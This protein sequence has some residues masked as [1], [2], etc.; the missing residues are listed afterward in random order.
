M[1]L[2]SKMINDKCN[3]VGC[4]ENMILSTFRPM[5]HHQLQ[6]IHKKE[7]QII[8]NMVKRYMYHTNLN[9]QRDTNQEVPTYCQ[10]TSKEKIL[11]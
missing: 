3:M 9:I 10:P 5:D 7:K 6:N 1:S 2:T 4:L 8:D 11:E